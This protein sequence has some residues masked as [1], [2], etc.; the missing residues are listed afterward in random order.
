MSATGKIVQVIGSTFD[1]E[2]P[3]D[4]LP[5]IY[6]ALRIDSS[7]GRIEVHLTGEV[8][9]HLGGGKV[10]CIALGATDGL[11][12]GLEVRDTGAPVSVPVGPAV[13]GRVFNL[14]GEPIDG[15]GEVEAAEFRSIHQPPPKF[16]SLEPKSEIFETGIKVIDLLV[17]FVR[18]GK[19]GLFGGAG[20]G[21]TI[22]I[23]ELIAR[24]AARHGGYSVFAGIGER[25]REGNDI[26]LEMQRAEIGKGGEKLI[27][28]FKDNMEQHTIQMN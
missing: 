1:V 25:S 16:E 3:E 26:W 9:Q 23:Q 5:G 14:L 15:R 7:D 22:I 4:K 11:R 6:N 10:R 13:L 17:P 8:H 18:G 28:A 27:V 20:L 21:K 12:R 24:V 19:M 2:F